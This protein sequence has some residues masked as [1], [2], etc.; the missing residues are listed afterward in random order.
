LVW[1]TTSVAKNL[2]K[3]SLGGEKMG[4]YDKVKDATKEFSE[5]AK[6]TSNQIYILRLY[7]SGMTPKSVRAIENIK[8]IV[9]KELQERYELEVIDIYQHPEKAISEQIIAAPTLVKKLPLPIKKIIGDLSDKERV[10]IGLDLI[11]KKH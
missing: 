2:S 4:D 1:V 10:I 7:V 6:K 3:I 11:P 9:D 5:S 8:E